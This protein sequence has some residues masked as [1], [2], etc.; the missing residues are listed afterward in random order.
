[1]MI[2]RLIS[3]TLGAASQ[4]ARLGGP[5]TE[6][7]KPAV[8]V[9]EQHSA[10]SQTLIRGRTCRSSIAS[11]MAA[12]P[13]AVRQCSIALM[14]VHRP[15]S[16]HGRHGCAPRRPRGRRKISAT[17]SGAVQRE[18]APLPLPSAGLS[19][20]ALWR[21]SIASRRI[22]SA[23]NRKS[24]AIEWPAFRYILALNSQLAGANQKGSDHAIDLPSMIMPTKRLH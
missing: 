4:I 10:P 2:F 22:V 20:S 24:M 15:A 8:P 7:G 18:L 14:T 12:E 1:M 3:S 21:S 16:G 9:A 19:C 5:F 17:S 6:D 23:R 11:H 13:A